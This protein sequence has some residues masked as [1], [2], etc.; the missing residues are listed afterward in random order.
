[1]LIH[2]AQVLDFIKRRIIVQ[3]VLEYFVAGTEHVF[4]IYHSYLSN[5]LKCNK[6]NVITGIQTNF[7]FDRNLSF[8]DGIEHHVMESLLIC[9]NGVD[10]PNSLR[11]SL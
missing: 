5:L 6:R 7:N 9:K 10:C 4:V 3:I 1:M 2:I 11:Y 8:F